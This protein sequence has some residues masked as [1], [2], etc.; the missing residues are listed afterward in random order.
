MKRRTYKLF[1]PAQLETI[2]ENNGQVTL[3]KLSEIL[4]KSY[5]NVCGA[6]KLYRIPFKPSRKIRE[7]E[8]IPKPKDPKEIIIIKKFNGKK[9]MLTDDLAKSWFY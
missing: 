1:T 9:E 7:E 3:I 2:K 5:S 4:G 6:L 8:L